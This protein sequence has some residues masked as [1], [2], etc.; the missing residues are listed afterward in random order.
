MERKYE[1]L[2][3]S[4]T[5]LSYAK[6]KIEEI[7]NWINKSSMELDNNKILSYKSNE[8][9]KALTD[10]KSIH[11]EAETNSIFLTDSLT[12]KLNAIELEA[13]PIEFN[14]LEKNYYKPAISN[15]ENFITSKLTI[16]Y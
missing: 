2:E 8:I 15:L 1:I 3:N 10:L 5:N 9:E 6:S 7:E 12:V 4:K 13:E 14:D 16:V 11:K